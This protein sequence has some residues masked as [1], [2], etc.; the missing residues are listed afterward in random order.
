MCSQQQIEVAGIE[1]RNV[2]ATSFSLLLTAALQ[3]PQS[4]SHRIQHIYPH[5]TARDQRKPSDCFIFRAF[6]VRAL[7]FERDAS[8]ILLIVHLSRS[9]S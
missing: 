1:V 6:A 9:N 3:L 8:S 4:T 7:V 2:S 5:H